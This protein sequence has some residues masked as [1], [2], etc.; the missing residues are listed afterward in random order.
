MVQLADGDIQT[1]EVLDWEGLHLFHYDSS[2]CSE[3]VRLF[4][5]LKGLEWQSHYID[6]A[7][8]ANYSEW[9]LGINPRGLVPTL[10]HDGRVYIESNGI[11]V[12]LEQAFPEPVLIPCTEVGDID[13]LLK[14]EDDLHLDLR[15]LSFRFIHANSRFKSEAALKKYEHGGSGTVGGI[16]DE[17][18]QVQLHF[19]RA[20]ADRGITDEQAVA[21][22]NSFRQAFD[23]LDTVLQEHPYLL[24]DAV[25]VV[26]IAWYIYTNRLIRAGYPL[27]ELHPKLAAWFDMLDQQP[28]WSAA[29]PAYDHVP[30]AGDETF[31]ARKQ[32]F[33]QVTGL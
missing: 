9:Y 19:W 2:S 32:D 25:S 29:I 23:E 26:D 12:Y 24:G 28:E 1:R 15:A 6:L 10:V 20:A 4:L 7:S 16:A 30:A 13:R 21:S 33:R 27:Y 5:A 3:K 14:H 31:V 8:D 17:E 22:A 18:K 11:I